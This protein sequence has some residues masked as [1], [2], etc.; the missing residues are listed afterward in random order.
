M[1]VYINVVLQ[2][3]FVKSINR[4]VF[5]RVILTPD[6]RGTWFVHD[7]FVVYTVVSTL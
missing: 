4:C 5:I 6:I 2:V 7:L 3:C 1:F